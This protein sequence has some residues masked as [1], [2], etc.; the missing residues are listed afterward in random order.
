[1]TTYIL[2]E[3][4]DH[5]SVEAPNARTAEA[6]IPVVVECADSAPHAH[7]A[8]ESCWRCCPRMAVDPYDQIL[9]ALSEWA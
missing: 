5:G 1:M 8:G 4:P 9:P 6:L 3:C 7:N 2:T